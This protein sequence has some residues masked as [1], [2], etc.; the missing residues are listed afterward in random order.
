MA[1]DIATL[2]VFAPLAAGGTVAVAERDFVRDGRLLLE[3][4]DRERVT[5]LNAT[6]HMY[7]MLF[8]AGWQGHPGLRAIAAASR[9]RRIW[10]PGCSAAPRRSGTSTAPPR[11][12]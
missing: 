3:T 4:L 1:V 5:I 8:D 12:R 6:P 2:E 11:P 9:S 7:R 10:R